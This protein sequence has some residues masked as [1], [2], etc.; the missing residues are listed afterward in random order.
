MRVCRQNRQ[1]NLQKPQQCTA[2]P[3]CRADEVIFFLGYPEDY[4]TGKFDVP[5][6]SKRVKGYTPGNEGVKAGFDAV[7][8]RMTFAVRRCFLLPGVLQTPA[9]RSVL[10]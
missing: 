5:E 1:Q 6:I 9:V 3:L 8:G 4:D 10:H 2:G 7:G